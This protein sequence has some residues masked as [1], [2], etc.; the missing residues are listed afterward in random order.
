MNFSV[1]D[2]VIF[3][4]EKLRGRIVDIKNDILVVNCSK[5][6]F[7]IHKSEVIKISEDVESMYSKLKVNDQ[8]F[9]ISEND[10]P[11]QYKDKQDSSIELKVTISKNFELDLHLEKIIENLENVNHQEILQLQMNAFYRGVFEAKNLGIDYLIV[12]H[13][14]GKGIL[15]R[16]IIEFLEENQAVFSDADYI[17]YKGGAIKIKIN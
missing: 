2:K 15:K 7:E 14:I 10:D 11:I 6:D 3:I 12:I 5:L 17:K 1:G 16:K 8:S 13:G 9:V 4:N